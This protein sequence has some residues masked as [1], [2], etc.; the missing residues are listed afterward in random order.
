MDGLDA[1]DKVR[2]SHYDLVFM[3]MQMPR[4]D[5]VEA[6]RLIR[7]HAAQPTLPVIA[8]T[9]N[10]FSGRPASCCLAAGMVDFITKPDPPILYAMLLS[11]CR[12]HRIGRRSAPAVTASGWHR[13]GPLD[14]ALITRLASHPEADTRFAPAK[15][16]GRTAL[17]RSPAQAVLQ[18]LRRR[19]APHLRPCWPLAT[20]PWPGWWSIH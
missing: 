19:H 11:G 5:G 10:A 13:T 15:L 3:D 9:A 6:T 8:M 1:L 14:A 20:V 2:A 4:L 16:G 17:W 18:Y 12:P 7:E